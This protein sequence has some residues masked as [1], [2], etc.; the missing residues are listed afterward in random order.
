M[1]KYKKGRILKGV[2]TGIESYGV[3][4][5]F[6]DYYRGLI[7]ISELSNGFVKNPGDFVEIDEII[8][9][10]IIGV[11]DQIGQ[12]NLS[13]KDI[14]YRDKKKVKRKPIIETESGFKT[15]ARKLPF[16]IEESLKNAEKES[17]SVD[18]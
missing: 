8:N 6:D 11:D 12:I 14:K 3:F 7:H 15:L 1:S 17:N 18:K 2:V 16:W 4:V 13:I 10:K 9:V 5:Q